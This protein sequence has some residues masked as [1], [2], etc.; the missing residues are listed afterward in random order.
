MTCTAQEAPLSPEPDDDWE[1]NTG[2]PCWGLCFFGGSGGGVSFP[3]N[4]GVEKCL[5][6]CTT[7]PDWFISGQD[8]CLGTGDTLSLALDSPSLTG[9]GI[10]LG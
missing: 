2:A 6:I 4:A 7:G 5:V 10:N 9:E 1:E 8:A 3:I